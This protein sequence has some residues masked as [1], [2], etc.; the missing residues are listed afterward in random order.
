M[1]DSVNNQPSLA[2]GLKDGDAIVEPE[3][4]MGQFFYEDS[5]IRIL[6]GDVKFQV[7][8][9]EAVILNLLRMACLGLAKTPDQHIRGFRRH[10]H[11]PGS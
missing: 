1:S 11:P 6:V 10:V 9:E 8:W 5:T 3:D 7:S 4:G 2:P